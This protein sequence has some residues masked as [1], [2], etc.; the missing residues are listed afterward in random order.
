MHEALHKSKQSLQNLHNWH[1]KRTRCGGCNPDI[2]VH[3][4]KSPSP[5]MY[6]DELTTA[7]NNVSKI[8]KTWKIR[9][10]PGTNN[11]PLEK[12]TIPLHPQK[13]ARYQVKMTIVNTDT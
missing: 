1:W 11:K 9:K 6:Q 2:K 7:P 13:A 12:L 5:A 3:G 10:P 4:T 8:P